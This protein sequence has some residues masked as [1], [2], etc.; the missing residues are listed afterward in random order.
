MVRLNWDEKKSNYKKIVNFEDL[1]KLSKEFFTIPKMK[2]KDFDEGD[3][4]MEGEEIEEN[5][6]YTLKKNFVVINSFWNY[7]LFRIYYYG[8]C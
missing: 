5:I 6:F 1:L 2:C 8:T 3:E 7:L 4:I